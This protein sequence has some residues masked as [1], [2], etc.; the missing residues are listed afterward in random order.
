MIWANQLQALVEPCFIFYKHSYYVF[1]QPFYIPLYLYNM[2]FSLNFS[3]YL[4]KHVQI[5]L[6]RF[7]S[8]SNIKTCSI[9]SK[10]HTFLVI[11]VLHNVFLMISRYQCL[12][13]TFS[14]S[15]LSNLKLFVLSLMLT[16]LAAKEFSHL[17]F[18]FE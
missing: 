6:W 5:C 4:K 1:H 15:L 8:S 7:K 11:F 10:L 18:L 2:H 14:V 9:L 17:L 16:Y 13:W 12:H 3:H